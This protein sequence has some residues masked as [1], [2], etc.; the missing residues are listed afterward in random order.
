L[1]DLVG[2]KVHNLYVLTSSW[3]LATMIMDHL[4][5]LGISDTN[6]KAAIEKDKGV[7]ALMQNLYEVLQNV[8]VLQFSMLRTYTLASSEYSV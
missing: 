2:S 6:I 1:A 5:K 3:R 7:A 4:T 8:L